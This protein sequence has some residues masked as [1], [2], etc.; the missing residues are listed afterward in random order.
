VRLGL[1]DRIC[2][3]TFLPLLREVQ[4]TQYQV[5]YNLLAWL[6]GSQKVTCTNL[7]RKEFM[8]GLGLHPLRVLVSRRSCSTRTIKNKRLQKGFVPVAPGIFLSTCK[9]DI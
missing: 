2:F 9:H 5:T 6:E 3:K 8:R 1:T 4:K 7:L